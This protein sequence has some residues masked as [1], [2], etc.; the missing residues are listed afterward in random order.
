MRALKWAATDGYGAQ[1]RAT[2]ADI[3]LVVAD[4]RDLS[5]AFSHHRLCRFV[6]S[7]QRLVTSEADQRLS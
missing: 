6:T 4:S 1:Q 2:M 5:L 7:E 3:K